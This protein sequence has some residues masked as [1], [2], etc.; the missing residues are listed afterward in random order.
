MAYLLWQLH[1]LYVYAFFLHADEIQS[2]YLIPLVSVP[3]LNQPQH[4]SLPVSH[5]GIL[6]A[7]HAGVGLGL[8]PRLIYQLIQN[9]GFFNCMYGQ[10]TI[11]SMRFQLG[12]KME[13]A[14]QPCYFIV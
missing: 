14:S 1:Y 7:I 2:L 4:G 11:S 13:I 9:P 12:Y 6:E 5:A 8:G 10:C 3:D